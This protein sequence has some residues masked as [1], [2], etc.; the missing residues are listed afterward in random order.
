MSIKDIN[1]G[2]RTRDRQLNTVIQ[3]VQDK[4]N[5]V[6]DFA[7]SPTAVFARVSYI[8]VRNY[9]SFAAAVMEIGD[10][11]KALLIPNEQAVSADIT[12]PSNIS[13]RF[14]QGGSLAIATGV[15]VTINGNVDAGL[16]Q[17]FSWAGTGK[18]AFGAGIVKE[19]YPQWWGAKGG[20]VTDDTAAIQ[21]ALGSGAKTLF[22]PKTSSYY[23]ITSQLNAFSDMDVF[24]APGA[25]IKLES[26]GTDHTVSFNNITNATWI[27]ARLLRAGATTGSGIHALSVTGTTDSTTKFINGHFE[28]QTTG[29]TTS[30]G[31]FVGDSAAPIF[32]SCYSKGG[33]ASEGCGVAI[34][35]S[36]VPLFF[37]HYGVG[38][39]GGTDSHGLYISY[40]SMA[41][42]TGGIFKGG[43]G[44]SGCHGT[45]IDKSATPILTNIVSVGGNGGASCSGI[46]L[47]DT[48]APL[49]NSVISIHGSGDQ[50]CNSIQIGNSAAP[51]LTNV[52]TSVPKVSSVWSFNPASNGQFRPDIWKP[53]QLKTLAVYV[54]IARAGAVL[55]IGT[56]AGGENI[57]KDLDISTT[58]WKYPALESG[59]ITLRAAGDMM[60]ATSASSTAGD[61]RVFY[62]VDIAFAGCTA[63]YISSK[64]EIRGENSSFISNCATDA[65][66]IGNDA[67]AANK[68]QFSN[69]IFQAKAKEASSPIAVTCQSLYSNAPFYNCS[70]ITGTS[71]LLLIYEA[72]L[73]WDPASLADGAGETSAAITVSGAA[74]G[75]HV[76]IYPPYNLQGILCM[77][78]VSAADTVNIRLQNETGGIIDLAGGT[79][80]VRVIKY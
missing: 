51:I 11:E 24:F 78:Y 43:D 29:G 37:N 14:L 54:D 71:N 12:V 8:D 6:I 2:Y 45:V 5:E 63:L 69:C 39:N 26:T 22:I 10:A 50:T 9:T 16:Y 34:S 19:V 13:L 79:W 72:T 57:V 33:G 61:F 66:Y 58:G 77:G 73:V 42:F 64:G 59:Y 36:G 65:V 17:I 62:V 46:L 44:A 74:F 35:S 53:Y 23:K 15:T 21:M 7:N 3:L 38:G 28:N 40:N 67:I 41:K 47:G 60:Y 27:N 76:R 49:L 68:L 32:E 80:K 31:L 20:D 55:D 70:F 18:V 75:D 1:V 56:T 4:V 25:T 48:C 52:K 30:H